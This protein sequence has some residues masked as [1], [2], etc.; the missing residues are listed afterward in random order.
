MVSLLDA[1]IVPLFVGVSLAFTA[2]TPYAQFTSGVNLVEVYAT[3]TDGQGEPITGLTAADFTV[4]EDGMR[5]RISA[6]AAGEFPL[7]IAIGLDR[8]FS[9]GGRDNRLGVA[10]SAARTLVGALRA[11]DQVMVVTIGSETEI[12]APLSGDRRAALAA[13]DRLDAWGTTPLY[14]A[15]LAALDAIQPA[16]GRRA[17]VLISDGTDRFSETTATDLVGRARNHDVLVYPVAIGAARPPVFAELASATGGRSFFVREPAAVIATMGQIA[18][19][20]RFQY[21]LGYVP[22]RERASDPS[23]HA[24]DVRVA[25]QD[26]RVRAREGY[27]GR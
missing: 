2:A 13:I 8:S 14:D 16:H 18:K 22:S 17:L 7:A 10:K 21:L 9:M 23:W 27:S 5:Q 19:E 4:A 24:I 20:L 6:Y 3:V 12:A 15:T 26:V 25:R 11:D 1:A